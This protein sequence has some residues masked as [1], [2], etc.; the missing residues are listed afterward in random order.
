MLADGIKTYQLAKVFGEPAGESG[1][2][3][4]EIFDFMLPNTHI[5]ARAST[6][7]FIRASGNEKDFAPTQPD[8]LVKALHEHTAEDAVIK[9]AV[10]WILN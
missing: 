5:I 6:K 3:F 10:S 9:A 8:V 7:M 1:N 2:D 4:G